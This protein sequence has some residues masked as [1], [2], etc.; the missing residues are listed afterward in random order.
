MDAFTP[1]L[2]QTI[3]ITMQP[4]VPAIVYAL[5]IAGVNSPLRNDAV[6]IVRRLSTT[7]GDISLFSLHQDYLFYTIS[8]TIRR[9]LFEP[10]DFSVSLE[11]H[12]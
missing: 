10:L 4:I 3:V 1:A 11:F 8:N 12:S 2:L 9:V 6:R 5:K 7:H